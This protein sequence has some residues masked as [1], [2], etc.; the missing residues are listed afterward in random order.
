MKFNMNIVKVLTGSLNDESPLVQS[1]I[2]E[3]FN[4][5]LGD[6]HVMVL[7]S[8]ELIESLNSE[9]VLPSL[10]SAL[11]PKMHESELSLNII[12]HIVKALPQVYMDPIV[13][14]LYTSDAADE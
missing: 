3:Y 12:N 1:S 5:L 8:E 2:L 13:C 11:V 9:P 10:V 7:D 6:L 14:L 4:L